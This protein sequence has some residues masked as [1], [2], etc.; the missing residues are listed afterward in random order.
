MTFHITGLARQYSSYLQFAQSRYRQDKEFLFRT[1]VWIQRVKL[2]K[3]L[4]YF[5][6]FWNWTLSY[7]PPGKLTST[8]IDDKNW[9]LMEN[10]PSLVDIFWIIY[11]VWVGVQ[12]FEHLDIC[13]FKRKWPRSYWAVTPIL[14]IL[15]CI[16]ELVFRFFN[17]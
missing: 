11:L 9:P 8:L 7:N 14:D 4:I 15:T 13:I 2:W 10:I 16:F 5:V 17:T 6:K 12:I 3:K 1:Q